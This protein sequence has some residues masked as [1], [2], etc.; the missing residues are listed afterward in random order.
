MILDHLDGK[1]GHNRIGNICRP[2]WI[3]VGHSY[4]D[5]L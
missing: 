3:R 1:N 5:Q 2:L 4:V